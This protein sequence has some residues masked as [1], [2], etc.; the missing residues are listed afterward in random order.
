[1]L[2]KTLCVCVSL[3]VSLDV[4][5][6]LVREYTAKLESVIAKPVDDL[7]LPDAPVQLRG[8]GRA[9]DRPGTSVEGARLSI[10]A[11]LVATSASGGLA[12]G[13]GSSG[14]LYSSSEGLASDDGDVRTLACLCGGREHVDAHRRRGGSAAFAGDCGDG[15]RR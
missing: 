5:Q 6:E 8:G 1:M 10:G 4:V 15:S 12:A 11:D 3:P 14:R 9:A 2:N 13:S 7:V